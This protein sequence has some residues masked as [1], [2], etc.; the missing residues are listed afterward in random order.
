[1]KQIALFVLICSLA[2]CTTAPSIT[3]T[4]TGSYT[5]AGQTTQAQVEIFA[6]T[7]NNYGASLIPTESADLPAMGICDLSGTILECPFVV[8]DGV[9]VFEGAILNGTW[10]G[11]I[12]ISGE[13]GTFSF[14]R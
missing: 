6:S 11:V 1:M 4:Y 14:S 9:M 7:G 12:D 13:L 8:M 5:V 10:Q 3:G 2:A